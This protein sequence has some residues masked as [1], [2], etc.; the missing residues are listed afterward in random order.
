MRCVPQIEHLDKDKEHP[1]L[2]GTFFA[3]VIIAGTLF[4]DEEVAQT[5][6][7]PKNLSAENAK[8]LR[9]IGCSAAKA[10]RKWIV[11]WEKL[12]REREESEVEKLTNE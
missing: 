6:Y 2:A 4:G 8:E 11:G 12:K 9:R 1:S 5:T 10:A 3:G 7:K